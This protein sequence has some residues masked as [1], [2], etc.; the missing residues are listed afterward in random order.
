MSKYEDDDNDSLS[1]S[2]NSDTDSDV[3]IIKS[4]SKSKAKPKIKILGDDDVD[5]PDD[6]DESDNDDDD[7]SDADDIDD[8]SDNDDDD[9]YALRTSTEEDDDKYGILPSTEEERKIRKAMGLEDVDEDSDYDEDEDEDDDIN[10]LQKFN[11]EM[12]NNVIQKH[13]PELIMHNHHEVEAM[14]RIVRDEDGNIVDPL[15]RTQP[16][17]TK[18]EKARVLGERAKQI[19]AGASPMVTVDEEIIDGYLI[20]LKEYEERKIPFILRRPLPSGGC[21][22]WRFSDLE[23]IV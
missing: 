13:H 19:N 23:L 7:E 17:I 15:H 2:D 14:C 12:K 9:K 18:F 4:K 6:D 22:Y 1:G 8:D 16:F 10:Y 20:A 3:G 21:E 11:D 5:E